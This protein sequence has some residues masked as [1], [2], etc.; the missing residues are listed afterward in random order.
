MTGVTIR[1]G[2]NVNISGYLSNVTVN[3]VDVA[4]FVSMVGAPVATAVL[5]RVR[6]HRV[7]TDRLCGTNLDGS[8]LRG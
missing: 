4:E 7:L 2:V 6:R 8:P 1:D 5:N 3:G